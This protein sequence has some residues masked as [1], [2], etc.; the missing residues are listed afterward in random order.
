MASSVFCE[1]YL[2]VY[3]RVNVLCVGSTRC[4]LDATPAPE[5]SSC[6]V[7]PQKLVE[8]FFI[9]WGRVPKMNQFASGTNRL[10]W[11]ERMRI[12]ASFHSNRANEVDLS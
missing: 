12:I 6:M 2:A 3:L 4:P 11:N 5:S 8:L 1:A 9:F 10:E 7:P